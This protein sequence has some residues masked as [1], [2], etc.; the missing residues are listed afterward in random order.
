MLTAGAQPQAEAGAVEH[1]GGN[2]Q[3]Q[4]CHGG[5]EEQ[6]LENQRA[7]EAAAQHVAAQADPAG[8]EDGG[9]PLAL[10]GPGQDDGE[11]GRQHVQGGAADGLI[12]P[13]VDGGKGQQQGEHRAGEARDQQG[14]QHG[15]LGGGG[16]PARAVGP[17]QE[18]AGEERADDH[19]ALQGDVN[20]AAA[21][22][23]H[24]PQR[25]QQERNCEKNGG[26]NDVGQNHH[27][28][29][30]SRPRRLPASDLAITPRISREKAD[31]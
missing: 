31:R 28:R 15:P 24:A 8:D 10:D 20:D 30:P 3:Q 2:N 21:L 6:L 23:E 17:A 13:E 9:L 18:Q 16:A 26:A 11:G 14:A 5:G 1:D 29:S 27:T 25:H 19:D 4:N 7:P 22:G 12:G